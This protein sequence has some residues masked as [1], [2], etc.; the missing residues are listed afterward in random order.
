MTVVLLKKKKKLN[1]GAFDRGAIGT[2][3]IGQGYDVR[4]G[5]RGLCPRGGGG[6]C[7]GAFVRGAFVPGAIG[8]EPMDILFFIIFFP[9]TEYTII[10][11]YYIKPI[12]TEL[13]FF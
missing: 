6:V 10:T 12:A 9:I 5:G 2:G 3:A 1:G 11:S 13:T 7:Q 4:E 8:L